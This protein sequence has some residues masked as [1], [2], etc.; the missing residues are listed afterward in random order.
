[1]ETEKPEKLLL[2]G[3]FNYLGWIK[4]MSSRLRRQKMLTRATD[5]ADYT[6]VTATTVE[7][8]DEIISRVSLKIAESVPAATD[9]SILWEYLAE[10]YGVGNKFDLMDE[11]QELAMGV[12]L[13]PAG[14][15]EILDVKKNK[16]V[17]AGG[18]VS[19]QDEYRVLLK[20]IHQMFYSDFIRK[21]RTTYEG[22]AVTAKH[23]GEI[24]KDLKAFYKN[25]PEAVR[26]QFKVEKK[27]FKITSQKKRNWEERNCSYCA[28]QHPKIATSHNEADCRAKIRDEEGNKERATYLDTASA[29][30]LSDQKPARLDLSKKG[31]IVGVTGDSM[32]IIG[33]GDMK[34]ANLDVPDTGFIPNLG[35]GILSGSQIIKQGKKIVIEL[36]PIMNDDVKIFDGEDLVATGTLKN[37]MLVMNGDFIPAKKTFTAQQAPSP[38]VIELNNCFAILSLEEHRRFGHLGTPKENCE[39]CLLNKRRKRN[40]P[41][42][43]SKP[44]AVLEKIS[45]DLQGPFPVK[46]IDGSRLN[47]KIVDNHSGY[48]KM[49]TIA[50][51]ESSTCEEVIKRYVNRSERQTGNRV[52]IIQT[53]GGTEFNGSFLGYLESVG[54][55][56]R[57]GAPYD[58][59][60]PPHAENANLLISRMS[61]PSL[62]FSNLPL[63]FYAEAMLYCTYVLN[64]YG[65]TSRYE[66]FFGRKPKLDHIHPFGSICYVFIPEEKRTKLEP[67]RERCRLIGFGDDDDSEE[68]AGYKLLVE[69]D[70][71]IIYSN[72][73]VFKG[74]TITELPDDSYVN[75]LGIDIF[76]TDF[77]L[78]EPSDTENSGET[79]VFSEEPHQ[80]GSVDNEVIDQP[81]R[82]R[83]REA[84]RWNPDELDLENSIQH[85]MPEVNEAGDQSADESGPEIE[86]ASEENNGISDD[87]YVLLIKCFK[88]FRQ[89]SAIPRTLKDVMDSSNRK[90][91]EAAMAA[92]ESSLIENGVYDKV[93]EKLPAGER[94]I[95]SKWVFAK[96]I[97]TD[98]KFTKFKARLVG[99]G[100]MEK[101]GIDYDEVFA[102]VAKFNSIRM[103][104]AAAAKKNWKL[105][106]DDVKTAFLNASLEA[107]K[108]LKLPNG[109]FVFIVKALYGLKESPREWF[110]LFRQFMLDTDFTQSAADHCIFIKQDIIVS[111]YVDDILSAG[112]DEAITT[113]RDKLKQRF[114]LNE[115]GGLAKLYLGIA[116]D[117]TDGKITIDQIAYVKEKLIEFEEFIGQTKCSSAPLDSQFQAVLAEAEESN[118]Y[119][120]NFPYRQM[121]GSLMYAMMGTRFDIAAAVSIVSKY[122]SNPKKLHCDLVRKIYWYLRGNLELQLEYSQT[123]STILRGWCDS[124]YANLENYTSLCGYVFTFNGAAISWESHRESVVTT[125]TSEAEYVALLPCLQDCVFLK[126]LLSELGF[127]QDIVEVME[128]NEACILLAKNPQNHKK[129]RHIQVRYHWSRQAI[130]DGV[131]KIV[132]VRTTAQLAD[133][134]TKGVFGPA[135]RSARTALGLRLRNQKEN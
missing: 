121:V 96:Q 73:A 109:K 7:A 4:I 75:H 16:V 23:L 51:R 86:E 22:A 97:D 106:Q 20:G 90:E 49:E 95:S 88:T 33:T 52:K 131:A 84:R 32:D 38:H 123:G 89:D 59:H 113:F 117:Q 64:R 67:V 119:E 85:Q 35:F 77:S 1:M 15:I 82:S 39:E 6:F 27:V 110:K 94:A 68:V 87:D 126:L 63:R 98:G 9:P 8:Y 54:I 42:I 133:I 101:F 108:W 28:K 105:Y 127:P 125:S 92:E 99:K 107:G 12:N 5:D 19:T 21:T 26:H 124:S 80:S 120:K 45:V 104:I 41:K 36:D 135:L 71:S 46:A 100:F 43:S 58:H 62:A 81:R 132:A 61:K 40:V 79:L 56:K 24:R 13:D 44:S 112:T 53:D 78:Y 118:E 57:K 114:R 3:K 30:S 34:L 83:R 102:P 122:C 55:V 18:E 14:F 111:V 76:E 134:F 91:W 65:S 2:T 48:I 93:Y 60:F 70:M 29:L 72:D 25:T 66:K 116:I 31:K 130:A 37:D 10:A 74:E 11:F 128:D 129:T 69:S 47:M 103:L 17:A 50:D 115:K